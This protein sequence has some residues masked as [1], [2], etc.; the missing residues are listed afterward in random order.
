MFSPK[1]KERFTALLKAPQRQ[2]A[3]SRYAPEL[4]EGTRYCS[5]PAFIGA[6]KEEGILRAHVLKAKNNKTVTIYSSAALEALNPY[7]LAAKM[8]PE[9]YFC[10]LSSIYFHSLTNQIPK[11]IYL[12]HETISGSR[13]AQAD[14]IT[15]AL[16]RSV[17]I[18]KHRRT[19]YVFTVHDCEIVVVDRNKNSDYGVSTV[20]GH[21]ALLPNSSRFTSVERALI[22]AIV[23][24][25]YNGGIVSVYT[26][27]KKARQKIDGKRLMEI[28]RK[29]DF[30]YPYAQV[31]G[32]FLDSIGLQKLATE[33]FN[34]YPPQHKFFVD[35]NAKASWNY[36]EKW[37]LYYP[38]GLID[39]NR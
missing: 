30:V 19:S 18:K 9:G 1:D 26:Y 23:S 20:H 27:F 35:R 14:G 24:P 25:Q 11:T 17:F 32:F 3:L 31:L 12:C 28:Y 7:E 8:F 16:L 38:N 34:T 29:L 33:I 37:K 22:D 21:T 5:V 2:S 39:E 6:L 4:M 36:D 10:N 15:N 13:K